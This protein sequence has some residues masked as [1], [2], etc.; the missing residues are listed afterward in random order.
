MLGYGDFPPPLGDI[1]EVSQRSAT[2]TTSSLWLLDIYIQQCIYTLC[3]SSKTLSSKQPDT[4]GVD[5]RSI[6]GFIFTNQ[7]H[8]AT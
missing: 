5:V 3:L 6:W 8:A 1:P 4:S 7:G 2:A